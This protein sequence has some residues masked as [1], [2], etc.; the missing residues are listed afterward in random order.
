MTPKKSRITT[1]INKENEAT[2]HIAT[3]WRITNTR[4]CLPKAL[5]PKNQSDPTEWGLSILIHIQLISEI[6]I[7]IREFRSKVRSAIKLRQ[8]RHTSAAGKVGYVKTSDL[9]S[10]LEQYMMIYETSSVETTSIETS[11]IESSGDESSIDESAFPSKK[12]G[13]H[14]N[15]ITPVNPDDIEEEE[16]EDD[17]DAPVGGRYYHHGRVKAIKANLNAGASAAAKPKMVVKPKPATRGR[18]RA[19]D[20]EEEAPDP[21]AVEPPSLVHQDPDPRLPDDTGFL[22][23]LAPNNGV[24]AAKN[25]KSK[26]LSRLEQEQIREPHWQVG[27]PTPAAF[28]ELP[29]PGEHAHVQDALE[30]DLNALPAIPDT[31]TITERR[32]MEEL[33]LSMEQRIWRIKVLRIREREGEGGEIAAAQN[34]D[35]KNSGRI[36]HI[37]VLKLRG[38]EE[39]GESVQNKNEVEEVERPGGVRKSRRLGKGK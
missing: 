20:V 4:D 35:K 23:P 38:Q 37:K 6:P 33:R 10:V 26:R 25:K 1:T 36:L 9:R 32:K 30:M 18:K 12:L 5:W 2:D 14:K 8:M 19:K 21:Q 3:N 28:T 16:E 39:N 22:S 29:S 15:P 13:W 7:S 11:S 17:S 31:A 34:A 27:M 24:D